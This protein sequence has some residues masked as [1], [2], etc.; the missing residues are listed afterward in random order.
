M[1]SN[2]N[3]ITNYDDFYGLFKCR[4]AS[5]QTLQCL[6]VCDQRNNKQALLITAQN[7]CLN[8]QLQIL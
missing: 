8:R 6:H 7:S 2:G 5:C 4:V 3:I 1:A